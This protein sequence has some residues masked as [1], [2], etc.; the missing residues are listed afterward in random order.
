MDCTVCG[1]PVTFNDVAYLG[2][3]AHEECRDSDEY[4]EMS[5]SREH[6]T[7]YGTIAFY[8]DP[9]KGA[10]YEVGR[11][12]TVGALYA[13]MRDDGSMDPEGISEIS[14]TYEEA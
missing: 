5:G 12:D 4:A 2:G 1:K 10:W 13:P 14:V 6:A 8:P 3:I 7:E 11:G 9:S